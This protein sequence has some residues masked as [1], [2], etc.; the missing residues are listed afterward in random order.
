MN[1]R[2]IVRA[3]FCGP[4]DRLALVYHSERKHKRITFDRDYAN[5][6]SAAAE[7]SGRQR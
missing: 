6:E 4:N 7:S 3:A 2:N 1:K 5:C